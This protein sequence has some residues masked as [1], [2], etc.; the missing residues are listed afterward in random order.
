MSEILINASDFKSQLRKAFG[1]T[2]IRADGTID[3]FDNDKWL[4]VCK[5][6]VYER[7]IGIDYSDLPK[8]YG[9]DS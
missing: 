9:H 7:K 6:S 5:V 1:R 3:R 2:R 8:V 4:P